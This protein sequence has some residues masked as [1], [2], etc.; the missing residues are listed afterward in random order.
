V[1][2]C[3]EALADL[4]WTVRLR[5]IGA[6]VASRM[7]DQE[8]PV[9]DLTPARELA[10]VPERAVADGSPGYALIVAPKPGCSR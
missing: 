5:R 9:V 7:A 4:V 6:H 10:G 8:L 3:D 2:E 1:V